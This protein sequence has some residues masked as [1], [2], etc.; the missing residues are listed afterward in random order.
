MSMISK[1]VEKAIEMASDDSPASSDNNNAN[2]ASEENFQPK[3]AKFWAVIASLFLGMF[4][5]ALDRTIV[6]TAIPR[7]TEEFHS[8]GDIGWYGSAYQL[9][10]AASQLV[11]GRVYKFYETKR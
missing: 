7:I 9:T 3:T 10:T 6:A 4:L 11:F 2:D 5:V 8:L 1:N